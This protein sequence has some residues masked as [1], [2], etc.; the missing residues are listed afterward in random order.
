MIDFDIQKKIVPISLV[1]TI[2]SLI[3]ALFVY[4]IYSRPSGREV[5]FSNTN[6]INR[7]IISFGEDKVELFKTESD[8]WILNKYR[9]ANQLAVDDMLS[10]LRNVTVRRP[11]S[12]AER[13]RIGRALDVSGV[14]LEAYAPVSLFG[15][16]LP[17]P[18]SKI[19]R[20]VHCIE[21]WED[22]NT[23]SNIMRYCGSTEL[24][25][26]HIPGI[27]SQLL[28]FFSVNPADW[29]DPVVVDMNAKD[30]KRIIVIHPERPENSFSISHD[31]QTG[32][33]LF[34]HTQNRV[35]PET[36]LVQRIEG[37]LHSFRELFFDDVIEDASLLK[38]SGKMSPTPFIHVIITG[39]DGSEVTLDGYYMLTDSEKQGEL[40]ADRETNPNRFYM[41]LNDSEW[42]IAQFLVFGRVFQDIFYFSDRN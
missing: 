22:T 36:I 38:E 26:V 42:V 34:D 7:I 10:I 16:R 13:E 1:L 23:A 12:L 32:F 39:H 29:L 8:R 6:Q 14:R 9:N 30:L 19:N 31:P 21:I 2:L 27:G 24:V 11:V 15:M 3:I 28:A 20:M 4:N 41:H 5:A 25:E 35:S 40:P 17:W 33:A 18:F 37:Y